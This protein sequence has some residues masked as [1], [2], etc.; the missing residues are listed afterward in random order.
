MLNF[1]ALILFIS[2]FAYFMALWQEALEKWLEEQKPN[3]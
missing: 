1:F 3:E 2:P